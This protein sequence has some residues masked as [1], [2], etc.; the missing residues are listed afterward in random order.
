MSDRRQ[1]LA[2]R[3]AALQ[4]LK[5]EL[6]RQA[7]AV[8]SRAAAMA[9][10]EVV[11]REASLSEAECRRDALLENGYVD[12]GRYTLHGHIAASAGKRLMEGRDEMVAAQGHAEEAGDAWHQ[13]RT[14]VDGLQARARELALFSEVERNLREQADAMDLWLA[15]REL[16]R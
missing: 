3:M 9:S 13:A 2:D 12:L 6:R 7:L 10:E 11:H 15:R 5:E 4:A 14:R 8:A 1:R 16:R